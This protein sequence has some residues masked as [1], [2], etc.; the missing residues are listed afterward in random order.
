[1]MKIQHAYAAAGK[2]IKWLADHVNYRWAISEIEASPAFK[3]GWYASKVNPR[4][5]N[6]HRRGTLEW[7]A[8]RAGYN[9]H[10]EDV[11]RAW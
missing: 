4:M 10:L 5:P 3:A 7:H 6:P 8:W 9:E 11:M 1:M 2:F